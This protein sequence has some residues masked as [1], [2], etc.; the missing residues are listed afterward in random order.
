MTMPASLQRP[1]Y[2]DKRLLKL[3]AELE[4]M[5]TLQAMIEYERLL[6]YPVPEESHQA[7][8]DAVAKRAKQ[9]SNQIRA[10]ESPK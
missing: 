2:Q 3:Q 6:H 5:E 10:Y 7:K 8:I 9:I 4:N 1:P